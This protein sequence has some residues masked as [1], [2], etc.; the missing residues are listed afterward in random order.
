MESA[1]A[2]VQ[3]HKGSRP[4]LVIEP[5]DGGQTGVLDVVDSGRGV[6]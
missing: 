3:S 1:S 2:D 5:E 6:E 4:S